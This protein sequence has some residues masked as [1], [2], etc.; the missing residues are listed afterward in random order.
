MAAGAEI[1][2]DHPIMNTVSEM[3]EW[4]TEHT[5]V[6]SGRMGAADTRFL[7]RQGN[8]PTVIFGPGVTDQMHAVN[9][10]LPVTNLVTATKVIAL[11]IYDWCNQSKEANE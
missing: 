2:T 3:F 10:F 7:I 8:T 11:A 5:P 6:Y 1:P 9:E 4:A